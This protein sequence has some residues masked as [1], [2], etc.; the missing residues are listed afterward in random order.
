MKKRYGKRTPSF[1]PTG[2]HRKLVEQLI[3]LHVTWDEIRQLIINPHTGEPISKVT[4][5]RYFKRQLAAG[6]AMLKELAA[7][8]YFQALKAGEPWAIRMAMRNRFNWVTEGSQLLPP[9]HLGQA[10]GEGIAL[11]INFVSPSKKPEPIEVA[12]SP[13]QN[14]QP[15]YDVPAI[16]KPRLRQRTDFGIIE[17]PREPRSHPSYESQTGEPRPSIFDRGGG[18]DGW[19]K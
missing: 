2:A 11:Q 15:N 10:D 7:S 1:K 12:P 19:M 9:D 14:A 4:L 17:Q 18:K 8:K 6:G 13:Y 3:A 5:N 16:E